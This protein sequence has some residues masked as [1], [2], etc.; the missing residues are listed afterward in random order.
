MV[1][2]GVPALEL[3]IFPALQD[4]LLTL[5]VGMIEA[6]PGAALHT[7]GVHPVHETTILEVI[8]VAVHLQPPAGEAAALVEHDLR[9][10]GT[11]SVGFTSTHHD[12]QNTFHIIRTLAKNTNYFHSCETSVRN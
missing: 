7:D 4:I 8:A 3:G 10:R 5:E 6:D 9:A 2:V 1:V 12:D 11:F